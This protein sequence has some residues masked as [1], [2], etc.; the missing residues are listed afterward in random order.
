MRQPL[1]FVHLAFSRHVYKVKKAIYGLK[2]APQA[3]FHHLSSF[4]LSHGFVCSHVDPSML[5][6][7]TD[8]HILVLLLYVVNI[9]LIANFEALL[10]RF[11][12]LLSQQSAMKDLG[13][14]YYFLGTQVVCSPSA[15]FQL[16]RSMYLI[17]SINF[18]CIL[19]NLL[20]PL[21][22]PEPPYLYLMVRALQYLTMTRPDIEYVV[23]VVSQFMNAP[24]TTHLHA[25]KRIFR[26]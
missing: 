7:H 26:Y 24:Y 1:G 2:Q 4:L 9:V 15:F 8:Y 10:R 14:L 22:L 19:V 21:L 18:S 23:H 6:F 3:W 20:E 17:F 11:I 12:N 25:L 13:D 16:N 5:I